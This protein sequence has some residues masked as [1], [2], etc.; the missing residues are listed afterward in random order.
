MV[1]VFEIE[2]QY[3]EKT[4]RIIEF[5]IEKCIA[6]EKNT[7]KESHTLSFE[8]RLRGTHFNLNSQLYNMGERIYR[9]E[10]SQKCPYFG[11]LDFKVEG[12]N[13]AIQV[14][15]GNHAIENGSDFI[16]YDWRSPIC[17]LYYDSEIG[18]VSYETPS[19]IRNGTMTLKR[20]ITIK[21]GE[22]INAI[23]SNLV[24]NDEL[25][26]P[27][28]TDNADHRMKTIIASIQKEQNKIIRM[29]D[30]N[31]IVQGVAGS[32]KTSVALHRIAYLLYNMKSNQ[33]NRFLVLGP[34]DYFLN[35]VS[36][37]L[38]DL[39]VTSVEQK[40]LLTLTNE[41]IGAELTLSADE[42]SKNTKIRQMQNQICAFKGSM[43]YKKIL[44]NFIM[45]CFD[46]DAIVFDDFKI[47]GKTVFT[48]EEIRKDL[49]ENG[50]RLNF[51]KTKIRFRKR[52]KENLESIYSELNK[53]Y[54]EIYISL[55]KGDPVRTETIKKSGE[56]EKQVKEKGLSLL[57]RYFK[58]IKK[59]CLALYV[60]F[61][62]ELNQM[63]ISLSEEEVRL[64][65]KETLKSIRK[66]QIPVEDLAALLY[67]NYRL[68]NKRLDYK[69]L[70][71]DE[72]QDYSKF[73]YYAL[74][75]VCPLAKFNIYGDMAQSIYPDRGV[76]SWEKLNH[77]IFGD[78]CDIM[79]LN[80]SYRTTIEITENAN[81][82]L[83][84]L[85]LHPADPVIRHGDEVEYWDISKFNK[86]DKIL[87]WM[88]SDYQTIAIIC[89]DEEE[90]QMVNKELTSN[91]INSRYIS[92]E[93]NEYACGVFT[94]S[95]TSAK[96]LE[97]DCVLINDASNK[98]YN[99]E[100]ETDM[101]L[102][103]VATTRALHEQVI[104]YDREITLPF[105]EQIKQAKTLCKRIK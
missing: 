37:V 99:Y 105:R 17:S 22:L 26:I 8:D 54:R 104:M 14:Y 66:K 2:K 67:L 12:S 91:G 65:Q 45:H 78:K 68:T 4:K 34:N 33:N 48:A 96:G 80:K 92:K 36:S 28:L 75:T 29:S 72:G 77:D 100:N 93:D 87:E 41:Y 49:V 98:K 46:G 85:K 10:K 19:G 58:T 9:L 40:T 5:E 55:P 64:L 82:V 50:T 11:R 86:I 74:K 3:L 27:Y 25:L 81:N 53:E 24:S 60:L 73:T 38:P 51:E 7:Q 23:D 83:N 52:F 76:D 84:I 94:L 57:D 95:V 101:H 21:N 39:E 43:E 63:K 20:Q 61:I 32:G 31:I 102:L 71:I 18:P 1:N 79:E 6:N 44:D 13:Q 35:Y 56:L 59:S 90:A 47:E 88:N 30:S 97:F 89:K 69:N 103:Y 62:S 16:V 15:I 42:L 70:V